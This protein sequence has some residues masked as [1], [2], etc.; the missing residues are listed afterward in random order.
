MEWRNSGGCL[1]PDESAEVISQHEIFWTMNLARKWQLLQLQT[2]CGS[3]ARAKTKQSSDETQLCGGAQETVMCSLEP[4]LL[5]FPGR[6]VGA[7]YFT[8]RKVCV[9]PDCHKTP[10]MAVRMRAVI[11]L[12]RQCTE[13]A[14]ICTSSTHSSKLLLTFFI[15]RH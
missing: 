4:R 12:E 3:G 8:F 15:H 1:N 11:F 14:P 2:E 5:I 6:Q 7:G 9:Y 13:C 10:I